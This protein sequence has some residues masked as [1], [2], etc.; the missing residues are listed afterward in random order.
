MKNDENRLLGIYHGLKKSADAYL[1]MN[2]F[3]NEFQNL[4]KNFQVNN[5]I[6]K[7]NI[8]KLLCDAPAKSFFLCIK[9]HTGYSNC[10]KCTEERTFINGKVVFLENNGQFR[11]DISFQNKLDEEFHKS[12]NPF[13]KLNMDL[14]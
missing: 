2:S 10:T 7:V 5:R 9:R 1:F 11:N 13:E 3:I 8:S 14:V 4:E 6:I 12:V